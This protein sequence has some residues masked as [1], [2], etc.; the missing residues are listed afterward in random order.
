M[1]GKKAA[2]RVGGSGKSTA[3]SRV[4]VHRR[5][6]P[7]REASVADIT[8]ARP[9]D[10]PG[11]AGRERVRAD[12]GSGTGYRTFPARL[13]VVL[14]VVGGGFVALGALGTWVRASAIETLRDDPKTVQVVVGYDSGAGWALAV[15]GVLLAIGALVWLGRRRILQLAALAVTVL[16]GV[17]IARKLVEFNDLGADWAVAAR[18]APDFVGFHAGLGWGAWCLLAGVILAA[19]GALVGVLRAVDLR[20]GFPG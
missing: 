19:F 2:G 7:V 10:K 1:N 9:I 14:S 6:T 17:A 12:S 3:P 20:R 16:T 18:R 8:T 4:Y 5:G 13:P 15:A 11:L